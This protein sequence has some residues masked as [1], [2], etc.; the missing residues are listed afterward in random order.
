MK[1]Y[2]EHQTVLPALLGDGQ[3]NIVVANRPGYVY[4]RVGSEDLYGQAFNGKV[5]AR[6]NLP[7][8]VGW[9]DLRPNLF[10][11]LGIRQV[12]LDSVDSDVTIIPEVPP[13]G[14]THE[15]PT[16]DDSDSDGSDTIF[17]AWRQIWGLRI[18]VD[19]GFTVSVERSPIF[20][21]G[22]GWVWVDTQ[23]ID[24]TADVPDHWARYVLMY[25]DE[26]GILQSENG[27]IIDKATIDINDCP[28]PDP[29][30]FALAGILLYA[31]QTGVHD[32]GDEQNIIDL[33]WP[34]A[35]QAK[36]SARGEQDALHWIGW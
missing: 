5:P 3:G 11:V 13:H 26:D 21:D 12:Y 2:R 14:H 17:A 29:G 24:L 35:Y 30:E 9:D 16:V 15:F 19:S 34:Q 10:Q 32:N 7:V 18:K 4:V 31:G 22:T 20:R 33:R 8:L 23:Q 1:R 28:D 25:L 27:D 6:D 36:D